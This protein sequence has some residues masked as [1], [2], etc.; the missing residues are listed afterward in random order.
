MQSIERVPSPSGQNAIRLAIE[1]AVKDDHIRPLQKRIRFRIRLAA[2]SLS[3]RPNWH[4]IKTCLQEAE[5]AGHPRARARSLIA[6]LSAYTAEINDEKRVKILGLLQRDRYA[7]PN[8]EIG[9][10]R[11]DYK[12][13]TLNRQRALT[14]LGYCVF[15]GVHG[16]D[17]RFLRPLA[18]ALAVALGPGTPRAGATTDSS[19][20]YEHEKIRK[21]LDLIRRRGVSRAQLIQVARAAFHTGHLHASNQPLLRL[22]IP[23]SGN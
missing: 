7:D 21:T 22:R 9:R 1:Q 15:A 16:I 5:R 11:E 10:L 14:L 23:K 18:P 12:L 20:K 13:V 3:R 17:K 19:F 8:S 4:R 6:I 2:V